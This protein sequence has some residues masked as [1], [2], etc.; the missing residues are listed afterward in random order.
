MIV[1]KLEKHRALTMRGYIAMLAVH[2]GFRKR[3]IGSALVVSAIEA[4]AHAGG[5]EVVLET[6]LTNKGALRLY[7]HLGFVRHK[8][9][10]KYY[11]NGVDAFRLKLWL[12]PPPKV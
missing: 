3:G 12:R 10:T 11:L 6:E 9:L 8:R 7:E 5:D 1:C 4:I 2:K